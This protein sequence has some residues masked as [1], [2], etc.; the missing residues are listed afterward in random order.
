MLGLGLVLSLLLTLGLA[1]RMPEYMLLPPA[2]LLALCAAVLFFQRPLLNLFVSTAGFAIA[3]NPNPGLQLP[4]V[5]YGL[6]YITFLLY[7][8]TG[9]AFTGQLGVRSLEDRLVMLLLVGGGGLSLVLG[10]V[11][12]YPTEFL[13]AELQGFGMLAFYFPVKEACRRH[14][15]GP[16][17]ILIVL[18]W[19]AMFVAVR[20]YLNFREILLSATQ[21]W[22]VADARPGFNELAL[23]AASLS[24]TVMLT[25]VRRWSVRGLS[26]LLFL[27]IFGGLIL[28]KSR[29]FW[30]A[31]ALGA[32]ALLV[33]AHSAQR[34][35]LVTFAVLGVT[36]LLA[37]TFFLLGDLALLVFEG[38]LNRFATIQGSTSQDL[39]LVNRFNEAG[40]VWEKVKANPLLGYG[41]GAPYH[42]YNWA[43]EYTSRRTYVHIGYIGL[44]YKL[45]IWGLTAMLLFWAR[46]IWAGLR[47][48][49]LESVP[50]LPRALGLAAVAVLTAMTL[51]VITHN[52]FVLMDTMMVFTLVTGMAVGLRQRYVEPVDA[53]QAAREGTL[54]ETA[55]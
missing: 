30:V 20:N 25:T 16:L 3:L 35:R 19:L 40:A 43:Y 45:G 21:A 29:A 2:A 22:E 39:S 48:Y 54:P 31:F 4:E 23:L 51:T 49:R 46:S 38:T 13:R 53:R 55:G 27:I 1:W 14:K 18:V 15:S 6:Y 17:V 34:R 26:L 37:L 9:R 32:L 28:T 7:W 8:Y 41:L 12:A 5:L 11:G 50:T 10:V 33:F 36:A 24:L 42:Y 47:V 44:W 52:P